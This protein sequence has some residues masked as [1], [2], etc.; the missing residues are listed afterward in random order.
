VDK[1]RVLTEIRRT[2]ALNGGSA[3]SVERFAAETDIRQSDWLGKFW[4]R[5]SDALCDAR[6]PEGIPLQLRMNL[7][8]IFP[9]GKLRALVDSRDFSLLW[10]ELAKEQTTLQRA[11]WAQQQL[12]ELVRTICL[13]PLIDVD[14]IKRDAGCRARSA[15]VL[16]EA[17][18]ILKSHPGVVL[19]VMRKPDDPVRVAR[20]RTLPDWL[21]SSWHRKLRLM[22]RLIEQPDPDAVDAKHVGTRGRA[23]IAQAGARGALIRKLGE[24]VP[25]AMPNRNAFIAR[26]LGFAGHDVSR[27]LVR[28]TLM[29]GRT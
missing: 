19:R 12:T 6:V 15:T 16:R 20:G 7:G 13:S 17:A 18:A 11:A 8:R 2:A 14:R 29:R 25:K 24:L 5:W 4:A 9:R 22:A 23:A 27:H 1:D 21:S 3:L 26:L 10:D 28:S